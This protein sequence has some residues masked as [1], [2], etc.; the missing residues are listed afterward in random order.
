MT[1]LREL[2]PLALS[3]GVLAGIWTQVSSELGWVTWVGFLSWAAYFAAGAGH[4]GLRRTVPAT[5]AGAV[6]GWLIVEL[7]GV[8]SFPGGLAL[9]VALGAFVMCVQ[10]GW[11]VLGFV[12]GAF[13]GCSAYFGTAFDFWPTVLAL[14]AGAV[15]GWASYWG[16]QWLGRGGRRPA[17]TAEN[18]LVEA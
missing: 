11:G 9:A 5:L 12:P 8:L 4:D 1:K 7:S 10:A 6:V 14:V 15:L 2:V 17:R 16:G 13:I 3:V 18:D